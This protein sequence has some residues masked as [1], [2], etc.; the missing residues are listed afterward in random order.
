MCLVGVLLSYYLPGQEWV[1]RVPL[2]KNI[3]PR[4]AWPLMV[5]PMILWAGT[6]IDLLRRLAVIAA[7]TRPQTP[8]GPAGTPDAAPGGGHYRHRGHVA[9]TAA[10]LQAYAAR[11]ANQKV[12]EVIAYCLSHPVL[13]LLPLVGLGL[14]VLVAYVLGRS[15]PRWL[16]PFLV[17]SAVSELIISV[18]PL[19]V[20]PPSRAQQRP[21]PAPVQRLAQLTQQ[22]HSRISASPSMLSMSQIPMLAGI[23]D[24]RVC[25]APGSRSLRRLHSHR[26][27]QH[28]V[29]LFCTPNRALAVLGSG[30]SP[31]HPD[32]QERRRPPS[33]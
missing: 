17:T 14:V 11:T 27:R 15:R 28:R 21:L 25:S 9:G 13:L 18:Q 20:S 7:R 12:Q 5:L 2:L 31:L 29:D 33:R 6:G 22:T 4:Y 23:A 19:V 8:A 26:G 3:L 32:H 1:Q 16:G 30:C 24:A 10:M